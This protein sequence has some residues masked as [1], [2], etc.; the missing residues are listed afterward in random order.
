[1]IDME[2]GVS[3]IQPFVFLLYYIENREIDCYNQIFLPHSKFIYNAEK[4]LNNF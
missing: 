1:M 2:I 3:I 4:K